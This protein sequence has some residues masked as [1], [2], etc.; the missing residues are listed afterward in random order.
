MKGRDLVLLR[1][2]DANLNRAREGLRVCEE[3][4]R[5]GL[6][7]P[8][9]TRRCQ[10]LRYGVDLAAGSLPR[11]K[12]LQTRDARRDIGRPSRR[13]AVRPHHTVEDLVAANLRRVQ[14]AFRVLEEF[15]RLK[16]PKASR[17]FGSLRFRAYSLE[18]T[19]HSTG[20]TLPH[21]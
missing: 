16:F 6:E 21:R 14:E 20:A 7:D 3:I 10:R 9:L 17:A 4:A 12:M 8:S 1:V 15:T 19:F 2:L 11:F 18:Q 13:G 5:L